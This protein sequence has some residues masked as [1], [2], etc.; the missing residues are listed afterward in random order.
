VLKKGEREKTIEN[1][2]E[3]LKKKHMAKKNENLN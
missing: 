1:R 2:K 3:H